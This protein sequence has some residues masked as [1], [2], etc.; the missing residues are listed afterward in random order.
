M[1]AEPRLPCWVGVEA[2]VNRVLLMAGGTVY[3]IN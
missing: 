1:A 3:L 2:V